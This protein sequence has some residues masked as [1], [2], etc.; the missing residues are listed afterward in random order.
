MIMILFLEVFLEHK[1]NLLL[2]ILAYQV[3]SSVGVVLHAVVL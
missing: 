2:I 1:A 3:L